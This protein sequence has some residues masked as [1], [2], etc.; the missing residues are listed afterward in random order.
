MR[1][2]RR[3]NIARSDKMEGAKHVFYCPPPATL[4]DRKMYIQ[5]GYIYPFANQNT[6]HTMLL[7]FTKQCDSTAHQTLPKSVVPSDSNMCP[8]IVTV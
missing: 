2:T 3:S 1:G 5:T 7:I 8:L 6:L 4:C